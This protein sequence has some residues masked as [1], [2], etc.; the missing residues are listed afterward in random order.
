MAPQSES[1]RLRVLAIGMFDSIHFVKWL[2]FF[3]NEP[4]EF[5]LFPSS[6]HRRIHQRL[7][8]LLTSDSVAGFK[9][10]P[11][12]R[13]AGLLLWSVDKIFS[14]RLRG[15]FV[16]RLM[17]AFGP[18]FVHALE[19]QHAGYI[20]L[21]A[22]DFSKSVES[23]LIVTNYGSD[24]YWFSRFP[25]HLKRISALLSMTDRYAAECERDVE[26]ARTFGYAGEILPV[27]PNAGGLETARLLSTRRVPNQR[28]LIMIKGYHGWAG[29]AHIAIQAVRLIATEL[30]KFEIVF[31]S[32]NYST[33]LLAA[34]L[35]NQTGL[36][37]KAYSKGFL[38]H[39][40][41]LDKL[42][43]SLVHVGLS[44]TDG[45]S[46]AMLESMAMGAIPVQTATACCGEWFDKTG[47]MI[48]NLN[49]EEV[50]RGILTAIE[51]GEKTDSPVKN[52]ETIRARAAREK[53]AQDALSFY[54]L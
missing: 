17:R 22:S 29:R 23:K 44:V 54:R 53:I 10:A 16:A 45:V 18:H 19:I 40:E 2:E 13:Y 47:V 15:Y 46:T 28:N 33:K 25:K 14:N 43:N 36:N 31:Y 20:Y 51:L 49:A 50:S 38:S 35:A 21:R 41:M 1:N 8:K 30:R 39:D 48:M 12:S 27:N 5:L 6:P 32:C 42:S 4:L 26:L 52:L 9:L 7:K 24:I 3:A 11:Y 37:V 34:L